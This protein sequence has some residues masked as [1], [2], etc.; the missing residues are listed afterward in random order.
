MKEIKN[1]IIGV[2]TLGITTAGGLLI[3]KFIGGEEEKVEDSPSPTPIV[4]Q[5]PEQQ[6]KKD[7]VVVIKEKKARPV[8]VVKPKKEKEFDW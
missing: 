7:T 3:N 4:I 5:M 6:V 1:A 2:I 8:E